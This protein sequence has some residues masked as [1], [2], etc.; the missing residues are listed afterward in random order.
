[1]NKQIATLMTALAALLIALLPTTAVWA[2]PQDAAANGKQ[3]PVVAA[4]ETM[5]E[6]EKEID[7]KDREAVAAYRAAGPEDDAAREQAMKTMTALRAERKEGVDA[8]REVFEKADW[9]KYANEEH[10]DLLER[11]LN[12]VGLHYG[13]SDPARAI[14]AYTML[15]EHNPDSGSAKFVRQYHL[16]NCYIATGDMGVAVD[17]VGQLAA[18]EKDEAV[19]RMLWITL[20]DIECARGNTGAA[21][22]LYGKAVS[23]LP[24]TIERGDARGSAKRYGELRLSLVGKPAPEIDAETWIGG[25]AKPLSAL[26]GNVTVIDFWATWC[27]PCRAVM[28]ALDELYKEHEGDGL[29]MI[30]LTRYYGNGYMPDDAKME[31]GQSVRDIAEED[32]VGHLEEFRKVS[33][34]SYPFVIGEKEDFENYHVS[35][36]PTVAVVGP[37]GNVIFVGVGSGTEPLVRAVVEGALDTSNG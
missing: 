34:I 23:G 1:M 6:A 33:E 7:A 28:P 15:L 26:A 3:D 5:K 4:Y 36:I 24:E 31:S 8:F 11:G 14:E 30:G 2:T 17:R 12:A 35:G 22:D 20:G 16:P 13:E 37:E 10:G 29:H 27:G 25:D 21:L 19:Q 18:D 9:S 32:F